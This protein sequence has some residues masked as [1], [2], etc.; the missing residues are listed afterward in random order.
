LDIGITMGVEHATAVSE[1]S[2]W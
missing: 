1:R 2:W